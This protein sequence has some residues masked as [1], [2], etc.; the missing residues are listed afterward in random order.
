MEAARAA[1]PEKI[2]LTAFR[3]AVLTGAME[4]L[5]QHMDQ[6]QFNQIDVTSSGEAHQQ[7]TKEYCSL[8]Q[9]SIVSKDAHS[10]VLAPNAD[11]EKA[12]KK[13]K[14]D[15]AYRE[16]CKKTKTQMIRDL[17]TFGEENEHLRME[18]K[19]LKEDNAS[20]TQ[21]LQSQTKELLQHKNRLD[22]LKFEN[23]KQNALVQVLSD[24]V[25]NSNL[26]HENQKLKDENAQLRQMVKLS[27]E[28]LKLVQE[29]GK[30]QH[31]NMLLKVQ[32]DALCGKIV[33]DNRNNCGR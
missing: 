13:R 22:Q 28:P 3:A 31:E 27:G 32:I 6:D 18:N 10:P 19:T 4:A 12:E 14:I 17:K 5:L 26:S 30:L 2:S 1:S 21:M 16:R 11:L 7:A 23:E 8:P 9:G 33:D 29:N 25:V 20:M 24:L 15:Q